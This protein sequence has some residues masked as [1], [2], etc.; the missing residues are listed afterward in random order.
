MKMNMF[1]TDYLPESIIYLWKKLLINKD[2]Q[3]DGTL[4][5][6]YFRFFTDEDCE[7]AKQDY[8]DKIK[9]TMNLAGK[10]YSFTDMTVPLIPATHRY[11]YFEPLQ[12]FW[13]IFG[14]LINS[15][16]LQIYD[17][18]VDKDFL[19]KR[20]IK[21][22]FVEIDRNIFDKI[23]HSKELTRSEAWQ[24][25][26]QSR[27]FDYLT[28]KIKINKEN[29]SKMMDDYIDV[30][31][32][33]VMR[34][35]KDVVFI[36]P[37]KQKK[38]FLRAI[39]ELEKKYGRK[40]VVSSDALAKAGVWYLRSEFNYRFFEAMFALEKA[41]QIEIL[42]LMKENMLIAIKADINDELKRYPVRKSDLI[43]SKNGADF[44]YKGK[45]LKLSKKADYFQVF[46]ALHSLLIQGGEIDYDTLSRE[47]QSRIPRTNHFTR[48][49]M[50]KFIQT[51]LTDKNNGFVHYAHIP[52]TEDHGRPL[53]A[54]NR[55]TGII[56]N[57][58]LG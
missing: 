38:D 55:G 33:G 47:I 42:N 44:Y 24:I 50:L 41:G 21:D 45:L 15:K 7:G 11:F 35:M 9:K 31:E 2:G 20:T 53:I 19:R 34:P 57:N 56:F 52:E 25:Q 58:N 6:S 54:V 28:F 18:R 14:G 22:C 12:A 32:T 13:M 23:E 4:R 36:D 26:S 43:I 39:A 10:S 51:N 1:S 46:S 17:I 16:A 40:M 29:L 37:A 5:T 8:Y 30:W 3:F 49:R 27:F 48:G